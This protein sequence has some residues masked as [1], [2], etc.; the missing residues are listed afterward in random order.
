[1]ISKYYK[2]IQRNVESKFTDILHSTE[3]IRGTAG[4]IRKL[5]LYLIDKTFVD[6]WYSTDGSYSFHW[7]QSAIRNAI[8]RHDNAPHRKWK[9][10]S[11]FPKHCHD[12]DQLNVTESFLPDDYKKAI[13]E[14][15]R[16][17]REKMADKQLTEKK[18]R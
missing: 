2:Q 9:N 1:M 14:F 5:R 18:Q 12:G 8:Y 6:I 15:L 3:L 16:L 13:E 7:K 17:V 11:T 4:R 10:V